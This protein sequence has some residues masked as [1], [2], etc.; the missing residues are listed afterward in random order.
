M[1]EELIEELRNL[2][3]CEN[4]IP[5]LKDSN[6][7]QEVMISARETI[8]K[9]KLQQSEQPKDVE[10]VLIVFEEW[11]SKYPLI[12]LEEPKWQLKRFLSEHYKPLTD[13]ANQQK[14]TVTDEEISSWLM[15][16]TNLDVEKILDFTEWMEQKLT[17]K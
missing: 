14:P 8:Q 12:S 13:F 10:D 11:Q 16:N 5:I 6:I 15:V 1:K 17:N 4:Y 3:N 7:W 9:A 2:M